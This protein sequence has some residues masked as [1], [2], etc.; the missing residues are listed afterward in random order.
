MYKLDLAQSS[1]CFATMLSLPQSASTQSADCTEAGLPVVTLSEPAEALRVLLRFCMPATPPDL[2]DLDAVGLV[3]EGG[4]K[5][6]IAWA[7]KAGAAEMEGF[8]EVEPVR[9]YALACHYGL[10]EL[11]RTAAT[12]CL[13]MPTSLILNSHAKEL[14]YLSAQD[15]RRLVA[16]R[17][18]CRDAVVIRVASYD[19]KEHWHGALQHIW[20][21]DIACLDNFSCFR[22]LFGTP[23]IVQSWFAEYIQRL[24]NLLNACT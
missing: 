3:L 10:E 16:Y 22:H 8:V 23:K 2:A 7:T 12:F 24:V 5:Y 9:V 19:Y 13:R 14:D 21:W 11:A 6:E 15:Y 20:P 17:D 1:P 18:A 4:K